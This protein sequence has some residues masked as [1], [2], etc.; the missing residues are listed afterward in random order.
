MAQSEIH[1][2]PKRIEFLAEN[3]CGFTTDVR[4][5]LAKL[6]SAMQ[7][8]GN[9]WRDEEYKKFQRHFDR[10]RQ[11]LT[12]LAENI[13]KREPELRDDARLLI[14]YLNKTLS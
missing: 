3:L 9:T 7:S 8:L 12:Q 6:E 10:L 5:E 14:A 2:D 11:R 1:A 4:A 13:R